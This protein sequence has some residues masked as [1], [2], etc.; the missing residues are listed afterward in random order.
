MIPLANQTYG[1]SSTAAKITLKSD[2]II[3]FS[4]FKATWSL[5]VTKTKAESATSQSI[6]WWDVKSIEFLDGPTKVGKKY[7]YKI[8][9]ISRET[10]QASDW[11]LKWSSNPGMFTGDQ[12]VNGLKVRTQVPMDKVKIFELIWSPK[13]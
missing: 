13:K 1:Q 10:G 3:N 8:I 11:Y 12:I 9:I 2:S 5:P 6:Q 4:Y 7:Y